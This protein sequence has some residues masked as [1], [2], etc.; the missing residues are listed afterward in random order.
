MHRLFVYGTLQHPPLLRQLLGREPGLEPATVD[1]WRAARLQGRVYPGLV[2]A[3]G[4]FARGHLLDVDDDELVVLDRFEGPQYERIV[5]IA[6]GEEVSAWRLREEHLALAVGEDWDLA[7]FVA[8]DA[9]VFLGASRPGEEH[10]WG[11]A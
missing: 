9:V 2:P 4:A 8:E 5:V 11:D 7:R 10:P 3:P 1:G 6:D